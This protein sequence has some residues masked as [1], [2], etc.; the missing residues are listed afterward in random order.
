MAWSTLV[1]LLLAHCTGSWAQSVLTQPLSASGALG[2]RVTISCTGSSSN[3]GGNY[4]NWYQQL[5]ETAPRPNILSDSS[6]SGSSDEADYSGSAYDSRLRA[7]SPP[8]L[9]GRETKTYFLICKEGT[10]L[11]N[12]LTVSP[13]ILFIVLLTPRSQVHPGA[14]PE[15]EAPQS[16]LSSE[17]L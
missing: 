1:L 7:H 15:S 4:V 6:W 2:Q 14:L 10:H 5:M 12:C 13:V 9:W 17:S 16:L 8:G 11:R 3:I